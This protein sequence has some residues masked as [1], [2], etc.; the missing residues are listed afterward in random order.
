MAPKT[1]FSIPLQKTV[2]VV[3]H[4]RRSSQEVRTTEKVVPQHPSKM[5][6]LPSRSQ[7]KVEAHAG[8]ANERPLG[9]PSKDIIETYPLCMIDT[10]EDAE[11]M[12]NMEAGDKQQM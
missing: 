2:D 10:Q 7:H 3:T 11:E 8:A 9:Q 1:E 5:S 4:A 12:D 6:S